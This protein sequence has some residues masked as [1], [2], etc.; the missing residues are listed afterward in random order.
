M[1]YNKYLIVFLF[2]SILIV[3]SFLNNNNKYQVDYCGQKDAYQNAKDSYRA[4]KKVRL[5]FPMIATDTDYR[6]FLDNESLRY[7]Y[8]DKKGFVIE[9]V[10][11]NH[12]VTLKCESKNSMVLY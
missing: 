4:G 5:Y 12:D 6:F 2:I 3:L 9:F 1:K 10:M 7:T 11:P 8:D